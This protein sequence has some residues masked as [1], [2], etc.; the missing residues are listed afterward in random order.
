VKT[1]I[2]AIGLAV[3]LI[4]QL[5]VLQSWQTGGITP[6]VLLAYLVILSIFVKSE[7]L[8][9]LSLVA[10]VLSD[11]YSTSD[12]GL[13]LGF[14][15][16]VAIIAKYLL[17]FGETEFSW[18]RPLVFLAVLCFLQSIVINFDQFSSLNWWAVTKSIIQYVIFTTFAGVIWYLII[19]QADDFIKKLSVSR[20]T[21]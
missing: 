13:Y 4:V 11:F 9:W 17:I 3:A 5:F 10:G 12:F 1:I 8:L 2:L 7:Q 6:N 19:K 15:L 18:W 20:V 21:R 14:Y 16:L